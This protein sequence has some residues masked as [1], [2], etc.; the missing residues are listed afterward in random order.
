LLDSGKE[1]ALKTSA[2]LTGRSGVVTRVLMEEW[3]S[4]DLADQFNGRPCPSSQ[5]PGRRN[6]ALDVEDAQNFSCHPTEMRT[7]KNIKTDQQTLGHTTARLTAD[8][9]NQAFASDVC[10]VQ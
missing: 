5:S 8:V 10:S 6:E 3:N 7:A 4:T 2:Q 1:S 9:Y